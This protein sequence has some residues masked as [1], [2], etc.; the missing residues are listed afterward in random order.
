MSAP[1]INHFLLHSQ[2]TDHYFNLETMTG[3]DS[4]AGE[5]KM[6][7]WQEVAARR[8]EEINSGISQFFAPA[9][10]L[11]D[12]NSIT[13]PQKSGI[14]SERELELTGLTATKLLPLIHNGTY[15]AVEVTTAFCKRAAIAHQA[16]GHTFHY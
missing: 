4:A 15:T 12:Q 11:K 3:P 2:T 1:L 6:P 8:K 5:A 9:E 7:K 16:V 13:L 14:L 10:L